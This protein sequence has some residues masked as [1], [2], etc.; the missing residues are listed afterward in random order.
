MTDSHEHVNLELINVGAHKDRVILVLSKVKGLTMTPEESVQSVPCIIARDVPRQLAEKLQGFLKQVGATVSLGQELADEEEFLVIDDVADVREVGGA[1]EDT[2]AFEAEEEHDD[3]FSPDDLPIVGDST[4]RSEPSADEAEFTA[5]NWA[6]E[7]SS[8]EP[9]ESAGDVGGPSEDFGGFSAV[10]P[11]A[12]PDVEEDELFGEEGDEFADFLDGD[13]DLKH[14][15]QKPG[16]LQSLLSRFPKGISSSKKKPDKKPIVKTTKGAT[17][18]DGKKPGKGL[19]WLSLPKLGK[20]PRP[21]ADE[22]IDES[23]GKKTLVLPG[24]SALIPAVIGFLIGFLLAGAWGWFSIGSARRDAEQQLATYRRQ[25][26]SQSQTQSQE[27]ESKVQQQ[28]LD[29]QNLTSQNIELRQ[30]LGHVQSPQSIV[31]STI[32][33]DGQIPLVQSLVS[34][35]GE[36]KH[37][38]L[39]SLEQSLEA[40]KQAGCAEQVLLDGEGTLTYAQV[41]KRFSA[42]YATFDIMRSNSLMTPYVAELKVPF[43]QE[44]RTGDSEASCH[45]AKS[46]QL[47]TPKHH[48]FGTYYG[49]WIIQYVFKDG[50]WMV[51]PAVIERNRAL[52]EKSF[53]V[54]SPDHA[55]FLIDNTIFP[56]FQN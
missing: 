38:H 24:G 51:K 16:I 40:Q 49:Y 2:L 22:D 4:E 26:T 8:T 9:D 11:H 12:I 53:Q 41:I 50:N 30:Q 15:P 29:I 25:L 47:L 13:D 56:E 23:A 44:I 20:T 21:A 18:N 46:F 39:Q 35:F 5:D 43:Q 32:P 55:K 7:H 1:G 31:P 3:L 48:E 37:R 36:L 10:D 14:Q 42:K 19:T 34:S 27:L 28:A 6:L 33:E 45:E 54:G 17:E 52:Y